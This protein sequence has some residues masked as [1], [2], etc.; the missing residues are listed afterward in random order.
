MRLVERG[1]D[2]EPVYQRTQRTTA[3]EIEEEAESV[4]ER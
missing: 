3:E 1:V 2:E 4:M